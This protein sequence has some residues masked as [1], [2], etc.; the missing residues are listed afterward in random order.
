MVDVAQNLITKTQVFFFLIL[1]NLLTS[2]TVSVK[3]EPFVIQIFVLKG[4]HQ[5]FFF[6]K[7]FSWG[8][9]NAKVL[10]SKQIV[11]R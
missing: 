11:N 8:L 9:I 7:Y 4:F 6:L 2:E 3:Q 10:L 5:S 1:H